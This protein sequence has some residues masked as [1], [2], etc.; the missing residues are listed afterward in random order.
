MR[1][2]GSKEVQ[3][4]E[5]FALRLLPKEAC[6]SAIKNLHGRQGLR[7]SIEGESTWSATRCLART[8]VTVCEEQE[9]HRW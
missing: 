6:K 2:L 1:L 9:G 3:R 5:Y 8:Y 7:N 4:K